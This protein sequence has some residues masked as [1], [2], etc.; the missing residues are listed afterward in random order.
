MSSVTLI[1]FLFLSLTISTF[2]Q[3]V[4]IKRVEPARDAPQADQPK[5][6]AQ[7]VKPEDRCTVEGTVT[8]AKAGEPLKRARVMMS[9]MGE[10]GEPMAAVTD[11]TGRFKLADVDPGRYSI[12]VFKNGFVRQQSGGPGPA[13]AASTI[14]LVTRQT[15]RNIDF[16]MMPAAV[17][18]GRVVDEDGE[19]VSRARIQALRW[20]Y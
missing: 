9:R 6:E 20:R 4:V 8:N 12:F 3:T 17:V 19:S 15:L 18:T 14:T 16:K 2:A 7:A 13:Q 1:V 5:P 10:P 11:A